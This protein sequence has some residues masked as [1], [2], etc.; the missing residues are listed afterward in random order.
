MIAV[1]LDRAAVLAAIRAMADD[2]G[3]VVDFAI[4]LA[5]QFSCTAGAVARLARAYG[6]E[7]DLVYVGKGTY[8]LAEMPEPEAPPTIE[9]LPPP[10]PITLPRVRWL[11]TAL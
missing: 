1:T 2:K 8:R 11:E 5:R 7:A 6:R 10:R 4:P 9:E 3:R